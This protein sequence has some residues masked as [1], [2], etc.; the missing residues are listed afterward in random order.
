V[1]VGRAERYLPLLRVM[2]GIAG[3]VWAQ[4]VKSKTPLMK[5]MCKTVTKLDTTG[6]CSIS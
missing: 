4:R 2:A 3:D 1:P 6:V 5:E